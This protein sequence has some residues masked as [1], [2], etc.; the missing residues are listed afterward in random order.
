MPEFVDAISG[1]VCR[2]PEFIDAMSYG[3]KWPNNVF[4]KVLR[5]PGSEPLPLSWVAGRGN[6][7]MSACTTKAH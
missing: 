5:L 4:V 1:D 2:V 3:T 7:P 6:V